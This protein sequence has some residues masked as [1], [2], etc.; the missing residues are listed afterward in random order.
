MRIYL[1]L[2]SFNRPFDNSAQFRIQQETAAKLYIQEQIRFGKLELAW[3]Y[4]LNIENRKNPFDEKR[5][6]IQAWEQ[7]AVKNIGEDENVLSEGERLHAKG[8]RVTDA[9]HVACALR[10][11]C[12]FFITTDDDI[13]RKGRDEKNIRILTPPEFIE[14]MDP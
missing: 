9:L 3:S 4:V 11:G 7:R 12:E 2:C 6:S 13:I 8:M 1:D 5:K 14:E 10:M